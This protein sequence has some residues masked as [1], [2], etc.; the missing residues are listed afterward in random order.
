MESR[1]A[2]WERMSAFIDD[3]LLSCRSGIKH[4]DGEVERDEELSPMVLNILVV[5]WLKVLH[6]ALPGAVRQRFSTQLRSNTIFSLR[7]DI[8]DS[9]PAILQDIQEKDGVIS[10]TGYQSR[11]NFQRGSFQRGSSRPNQRKNAYGYRRSMKC[12]LCESAGRQEANTHFLSACPFLPTEDRQYISKTREVVVE[13]ESDG[14]QEE[15]DTARTS[16]CNFTH[17]VQP[18]DA[19]TCRVDVI[20][21]PVLHISVGRYVSAF[22][23]D[24]GAETN[25]INEKECKKLGVKIHPTLQRANMADGLSPLQT[26]GEVHF[27]CVR[28]H[29]T[30]KFNGLVVKNLNC[31]ILAG[32]PFLE[33]NDVFLRPKMR[34][35]YIGD[36]CSVRYQG[37]KPQ[38]IGNTCT[39]SIL[40]IPHQLCLLP[41]EGLSM[42][43]PDSLKGQEVAIEPRVLAPSVV[44][45]PDWLRCQII[46]SSIEG[47]ITV[48]NSANEPVLLKRN[49]QICQVVPVTDVSKL[50]PYS[51]P[52]KKVSPGNSVEFASHAVTVDPS[53]IL[54]AEDRERFLSLNL[55]YDNVFSSKLGFY[56]GHSGPFV[57]IINMGDSLPPQRRGRIPLYN[58]TNLELLQEKFD[59]LLSAG[60]FS[61]PEDIGIA[62]EYV[63]PSFL[64]KKSDGGHRLVT[65][66]TELGIYARPQ[67]SVMPNVDETLRQIG[68]WKFIVKT[69]LKQAYYQIP[70]SDSSLK[71]VGVVTPFRGTLVYRR[72]VMGLPGSE[73]SLECLLSRVLGDLIISGSTV[74]LADD[75]YCGASSTTKL[76]EVWEK[77][78]KLLQ[79]NGLKLSPAKTV[80][81]PTSTVILGWLWE[82]GTIRST[83]HRLNALLQCSPPETVT[84][85]RSFIGSYKFLSRVLPYYSYHLDP[86]EKLCAGTHTSTE[87]ISWT[88]ELLLVFDKAKSHLKSAKTITL[89]HR[90][91]HLQIVTDASALG[92]ASAMYSVRD[93]KPR[94]SGLFNAKRKAPQLGWLPCEMEAL[95]IAVGVKHFG[96]YIIQ[97]LHKTKVFTDSKPC[98][99]AYK[100]LRRGEFSSSSRVMTFLSTVSHYQ[101]ELHHIAGKNNMFSDFNSRNPITCDGGC[102]VCTFVKKTEESVVRAVTIT[103]VLS[104]RCSVPYATRSTWFQVQQDCKDLSRVYKY[105]KDGLTP[106]KKNRRILDVKRYMN[107]V[108]LSSS[109]A[110]GLMVVL[111][112]LPLG[113]ARQRIVVP[114]AIVDGLLTAL[115]LRLSHPSKHQ[116]KE[117]FNRAFFALDVDKAVD[118]T[119]Q[120]CHTCA[121]LKRIPTMFKHQSTSIPPDVLGRSYSA[122]VIRRERQFI[123]VV[124]ENVS[125]LTDAVF[126]PREDGMSL[127]EGLVKVL[128][129]LRSPASPP[130]SIRVDPATGFQS[131]VKDHMLISHGVHLELGEAKNVNK[132]P[133]A[134]RCISEVHAEITKL[135]PTGGPINEVTLAIAVS[136][137]NSR[138]RGGGLTAL[139]VWTQ[140]DMSTGEQIP[141]SDKQLAVDKYQ[142]RRKGHLPSARY[143]SRGK[144]ASH[145]PVVNVGDLVY[146]YQDRDKTRARDKYLV[147]DLKGAKVAV[148]KFTGSQ[149]RS[150]RYWVDLV[151]IIKVDTVAD[152]PHHMISSSDGSSAEESTDLVITGRASDDEAVE[153]HQE[154][155]P[156]RPRRVIKPP[157]HLKDFVCGD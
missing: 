41:G 29:H 139:E 21:S 146:L 55:K 59:E 70:L 112:E 48:H 126:I 40:R 19:T 75:L 61:K 32:M 1:E 94:L 73:S 141:L 129:R 62:V 22:T 101:V 107:A 5:L 35:I 37:G 67:P 72:A 25:L 77:V 154:V 99:E 82:Q 13:S 137:L 111:Q 54:D 56:N 45:V 76:L 144:L 119:L 145:L 81:C 15:Y 138:I 87:K 30:F 131:I 14:C 69:D 135:Q 96:P 3:N 11:N 28:D 103:D 51:V 31:D 78:L 89:P 80:C 127:K 136:N 110:D 18:K 53:S 148:Q 113:S 152:Q 120:N 63:N 151:D 68:Q 123:L 104:G 108:I 128:S 142:Q 47:Q 88:D 86:L 2:L 118:R 46:P 116:L 49:E 12:C 100:K 27:S 84:K 150:R 90:D 74:K 57:H 52:V 4:L 24:S 117:V 16:E 60:V 42:Q 23:L 71:Y 83:P 39:A 105:L 7:E 33:G 64:V 114:R 153:I 125:S 36:C 109:P 130:V 121:S 6:C 43:L 95:S 115:H 157:G 58:R 155:R 98:V 17:T 133:I 79:L 143:R 10:R 149:L 38:L 92:L 34:T 66:F 102:Q 132:N 26:V 140:R 20:P 124:R 156:Q 106:S 65:A 147:V 50:E 134:E 91:D 97:S 85:L 8:S 9:V 44:A 93:S 122:D